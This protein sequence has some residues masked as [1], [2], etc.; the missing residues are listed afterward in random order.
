MDFERYRDWIQA[1]LD[2][3]GNTHTFEDIV[4]GITIG[5][6]QLWPA[7]RGCAVTE[8]V[9]YPQKKVL[10]LFL[11]GGEL[12][13]F[14]DMYEDAAAWGRSQGCTAMTLSGRLGWERVMK[15]RGWT[16]KMIVMEKDI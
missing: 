6:L 14:F 8:I 13:Q 12:E 5:R 16:A 7:P 10:N 9:V 4:H 2:H 1:A 11:A 15:P 3:G